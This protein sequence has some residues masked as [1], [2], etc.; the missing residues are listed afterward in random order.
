MVRMI[1]NAAYAAAVLGCLMAPSSV[2]AADPACVQCEQAVPMFSKIPYLNR[3][4][5]N[6]GVA[7]AP[8]PGDNIQI[9]WEEVDCPAGKCEVAVCPGKGCE[10]NVCEV[11]A[12][13]A[14]GCQAKCCD[15]AQVCQPRCFLIPGSDGVERVGIDFDFNVCESDT[16]QQFQF[17]PAQTVAAAPVVSAQHPIESPLLQLYSSFVEQLNAVHEASRERESEL[18]EAIFEARVENATLAAK[19]AAVEEHTQLAIENALLKAKLEQAEEKL[20][21]LAQEQ[22]QVADKATTKRKR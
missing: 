20:A 14:A 11:K 22:T 12:C 10:A 6:V 7:A 13:A 3:L 17:A 21:K 16:C 1:L 9:V 18:I 8:A 19:L 2:Q 15:A 4:F 5:K